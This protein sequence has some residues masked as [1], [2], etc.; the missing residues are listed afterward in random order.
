MRRYLLGTRCC[1]SEADQQVGP[2]NDT[3]AE[4]ARLSCGIGIYW[5][6]EKQESA[7]KFVRIFVVV[8]VFALVTGATGQ[9]VTVLYSFSGPP[10][11]GYGPEATLI[12]GTDGSFYGT[13]IGFPFFITSTVFRVSSSGS[14]TNLYF[15]KGTADGGE[16]GGGLVQ[17]RDGN[18]Y[19]TTMEGGNTNLHNGIGFGTIFRISP[20]GVLTT[21][22]C[23]A[24]PP[25]GNRPVGGLVQGADGNL[26]GT[27]DEGGSTNCANGCGTVFRISPGGS[28]TSLHS[29]L[30]Y[31]NDGQTPV[32]LEQGND[33]NFYG[34]TSDTFYRIGAGG[35]Y[36]NLYSFDD[37]YQVPVP[38]P[39]VQGA[40]GYFYGTTQQGGYGYGM[41]FR[42]SSS[43]AYKTLYLFGSVGNDGHFPQNR[44]VL[45]SDG[46]F[47]GTTVLGGIRGSGTVFRIS[48]SGTYTNLYS[49]GNYAADGAEPGAGLVQGSDGNFYGT[50][51]LG[52]T[53]GSGTVFRI[54][55]P[56][57]PPANQISSTL[58][59]SSGTNAVFTIPSVA[60]ETYQLQFAT[61]LVAGD[62]SDVVGVCMSNSIGAA[63]TVTNFGG[64]SGPQGFYRFAITP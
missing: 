13:A 35:S 38:N 11:D 15:F 39:L 44:L 41:A 14:L 16:P 6:A 2:T 8:A 45:G 12:Q 23:F 42:I 7:V 63:L 51:S 37:G 31:P 28:Y 9:T 52:G 3:D 34:T 17:G 20:S 57:N 43:G 49:F 4:S 18:F 47:Y 32:G 56:L 59:D 25:D 36:T 55:I 24:G 5:L 19:G 30:G 46:N 53:Y 61:D 64:A 10:T 27:C 48:S 1:A 54:S 33:G 21:L 62:W 58:L 29:F 50:T 60:G 26:Y 22:Y 40:D